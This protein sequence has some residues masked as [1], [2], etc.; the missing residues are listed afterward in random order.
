MVESS[1]IIKDDLSQYFFQFIVSGS[2]FVDIKRMNKP[3]T[4][5]M[6]KYLYMGCKQ[7]I[8]VTLTHYLKCNCI[9]GLIVK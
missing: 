6:I 7:A 4:Q 1:V 8:T 5:C 9:T 3:M 2:T